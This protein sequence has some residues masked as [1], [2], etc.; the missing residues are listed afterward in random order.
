[1]HLHLYADDSQ[2]YT[3][4]VVS[5]IT[6]AVHRLAACIADVNNSISV[7]VGPRQRLCGWVQDICYNN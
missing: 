1:M 3:S 4:V 7:S 2:I 6:S 5:D